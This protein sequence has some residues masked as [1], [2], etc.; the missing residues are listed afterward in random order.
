[1]YIRKTKK[2]AFQK[3][4]SDFYRQHGRH[5][6]PWRKSPS[7]YR[8]TVSEI[9]L[10]QTQVDRVMPFFKNWMKLFPNWKALA[11]ASQIDI[12]RAWKGLGYNSRALRLHRLAKLV[13]EKY[14]GKLPQSR[15]DLESLPGIGPYTSGAIRAFALNEPEVFI[16]TNIRRIFIH[17][18]FSDSN[19]I[20]DSQIYTLVEK[21]LPQKLDM[22]YL[23]PRAWYAALMDYG[24]V[25]AKK[26]PNPN[27]RSK[28]YAKQS[29]FKGSDREI[30][31]KILALLL[32]SKK[33][34]QDALVK[35][36]DD[37]KI[38]IEKI[39]TTLV[40]EGFI[41]VTKTGIRLAK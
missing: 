16:E 28:H 10:Q 39:L 22:Y 19:D 38:R 15:K 14:S 6:L 3:I 18:F 1:M 34:T 4:I 11:M 13:T 23:E 26:I 2:E 5:Q 25:L 30:R 8:V 9:M 7:P 40:A 31:G 27:R 41:V 24:S 20:H 32:E 21:T 29:T 12:L 36:I 17:H 33:L 35:E 37:E